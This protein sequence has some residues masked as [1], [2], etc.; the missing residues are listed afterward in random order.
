V[1]GFLT[2]STVGHHCCLAGGMMQSTHR[3]VR[4]RWVVQ[5][6][7]G[8]AFAESPE[9]ER[10]ASV[11]GLVEGVA[12]RR[13]PGL[14]SPAWVDGFRS[15]EHDGGVRPGR[16]VAVVRDLSAGEEGVVGEG[17]LRF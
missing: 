10:R 12:W 2:T 16:A 5:L 9:T 8:P 17:F 14:I 15:S 3:P 4:L 13:R 1:L 6:D 11:G 7:S